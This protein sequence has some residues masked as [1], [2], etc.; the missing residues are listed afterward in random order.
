MQ[1]QS[2]WQPSSLKWTQKL[3]T[4]LLS[5]TQVALTATKK[6]YDQ[7]E[8]EALA[9]VWACEHLHVYIYGKTV[10]VYTDHKPG[11]FPLLYSVF[12]YVYFRACYILRLI[13]S[14]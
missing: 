1:V 4:V 9:V 12:S 11:H 5:P 14:C 7:T 6:R 10:T 2:A 13:H 8:R 3:G